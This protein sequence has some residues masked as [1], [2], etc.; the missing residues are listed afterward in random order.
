[1]FT[2]HNPVDGVV[3]IMYSAQMW[4]PSR[5][6]AKEST[7]PEAAMSKLADT[8]TPLLKKVVGLPKESRAAT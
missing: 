8:D 2:V 4:S 3:P 5:V 1:M 7:T 6:E